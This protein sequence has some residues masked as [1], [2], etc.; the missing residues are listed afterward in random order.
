MMA[1]PVQMNK[2]QFLVQASDKQHR[3]VSGATVS[4]DLAMPGMDMGRNV[5]ALKEMAA[6]PGSYTGTGRFPMAGDWQAT[7]SAERGAV[8]ESQTFPISVH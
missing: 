1:P 8:Q 3:P 4:L 2:T 5:V 7:V 6:T